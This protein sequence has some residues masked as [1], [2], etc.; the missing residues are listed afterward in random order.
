MCVIEYFKWVNF[1][2]YELYLNKTIIKKFHIEEIKKYK[3]K[4]EIINLNGFYRTY[5]LTAS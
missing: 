1:K 5:N 3:K 2:A 4:D